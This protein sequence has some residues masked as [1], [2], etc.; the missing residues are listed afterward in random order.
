MRLAGNELEVGV[1]LGGDEGVVGEADEGHGDV[2]VV[3][4]AE[5]VG[6]GGDEDKGGEECNNI[7][8]KHGVAGG[9]DVLMGDGKGKG[10]GD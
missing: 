3:L 6:E 2:V 1:L 5:G 7:A 10:A 8:S 9:A 4:G